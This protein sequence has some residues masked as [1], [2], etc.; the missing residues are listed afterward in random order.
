MTGGLYGSMVKCMKSAI[1][2]AKWAI[3]V[4]LLTAF[5]MGCGKGYRLTLSNGQTIVSPTKPKLDQNGNYVVT[6][7]AGR[8]YT[9]NQM[10]VRV[11]EPV[12]GSQTES[13]FK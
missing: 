8:T 13:N 6:D 3:V 11:I 7:A 10:R 12:S 2:N 5:A 4:V 1:H 9:I